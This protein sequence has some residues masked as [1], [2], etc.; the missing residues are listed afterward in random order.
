[1]GPKTPARG[2]GSRIAREGSEDV[3]PVD[4]EVAYDEEVE[5]E[6]VIE[7]PKTTRKNKQRRQPSRGRVD[8]RAGTVSDTEEILTEEPPTVKKPGRGRAGKNEEV[9]PRLPKKTPARGRPRKNSRA[10][11]PKAIEHNDQGLSDDDEEEE[12]EDEEGAAQ[13][14]LFNAKPT[15]KK[16]SAKGKEP[17]AEPDLY[18][19]PESGVAGPSNALNQDVVLPTTEVDKVQQQQQ[20]RLVKVKAAKVQ[21]ADSAASQPMNQPANRYTNRSAN[22]PM[23]QSA[24]HHPRRS[25]SWIVWVLPFFLLAALFSGVLYLA[26]LQFEE[27][28]ST[29][30]TRVKTVEQQLEKVMNPEIPTPDPRRVDWFSFGLGA[31]PIVNLCTPSYRIPPPDPPKKTWPWSNPVPV[32]DSDET[33]L[34]RV[35]AGRIFSPLN[36]SQALL[37]WDEPSPR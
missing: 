34:K 13:S 24:N 15:T 26:Y 30:N 18:S 35:Q 31:L 36:A 11:H 2:R 23:N 6:P 1:M 7:T 16:K 19:I 5:E 21:Q 28:N 4:R 3:V 33:R 25:I 20:Q 8:V 32:I 29:T 10:A 22:Q 37:H 27:I 17:A 9:E 14:T 12:E